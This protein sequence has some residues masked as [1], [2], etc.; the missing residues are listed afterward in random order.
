MT[1]QSTHAELIRDM[2]SHIRRLR[3]ALAF[4]ADERNWVPE[5][6][7]GMDGVARTPTS[8]VMAAGGHLPAMDALADMRTPM[9]YT[10]TLEPPR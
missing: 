10:G 5:V 6:T 1:I 4:Y 2:D 3:A 8:R 9:S 7:I